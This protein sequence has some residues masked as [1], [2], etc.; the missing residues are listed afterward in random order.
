MLDNQTFNVG[1]NS[2]SIFYNL[3]LDSVHFET[4]SGFTERSFQMEPG[5]DRLFCHISGIDIEAQLTGGLK[6]LHFI[7]LDATGISITNLTLNFDLESL[8]AADKVHWKLVDES[9]F[10]FSSMAVHMK[11]PIL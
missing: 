6:L 1:Y 11:N 2:G 10:S 7:P 9:S 8:A 5:T 3:F 4:V